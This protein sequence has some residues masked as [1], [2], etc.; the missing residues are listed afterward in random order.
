MKRI[1]ERRCG[2]WCWRSSTTVSCTGTATSSRRSSESRSPAAAGQPRPAALLSARPFGTFGGPTTPSDFPR[3]NGL[4]WTARG[5]CGTCMSGGGPSLS[6]QRY[7]TGPQSTGLRAFQRSMTPFPPTQTTHTGEGPRFLGSSSG[8]TASTSGWGRP[9]ALSRRGFTL[10]SPISVSPWSLSQ[11]ISS[12]T[13]PPSSCQSTSMSTGQRLWVRILWSLLRRRGRPMPTEPRWGSTSG[14]VAETAASWTR[15]RSRG[16][17]ELGWSGTCSE[18]SGPKRSR[19]SRGGGRC[20]T[21]TLP[22]MPQS[23]STHSGRHSS[24]AFRWA[25]LSAGSEQGGTG[26]GGSVRRTPKLCGGCRRNL[27]RSTR[28]R[29]PREAAPH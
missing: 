18:R 14:S 16:S 27:R 7:D 4:R 12:G 10:R 2:K 17:I 19:C 13:A 22:P 21:P 15:S 8:C 3:P 25:S 6:S 9:A 1:P 26:P 5:L 11:M 24:T 20:T 23:R 29:H 28:R